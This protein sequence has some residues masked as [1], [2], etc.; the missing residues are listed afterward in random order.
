M[1]WNINALGSGVGAYI[2]ADKTD[3]SKAIFTTKAELDTYTT[4]HPNWFKSFKSDECVAIGTSDVELKYAYIKKKDQWVDIA[5]NFKGDKGEKGNTGNAGADGADGKDGESVEVLINGESK[6]TKLKELDVISAGL[7]TIVQDDKL[8]IGNSAIVSSQGEIIKQ[9]DVSSG[10]K[11]EVEDNKLTIG[12]SDYQQVK[13]EAKKQDDPQIVEINKDQN[14]SNKEFIINYAAE[15]DNPVIVKLYPR[16]DTENK[17]IIITTKFTDSSDPIITI[18][19]IFD[20]DSNLIDTFNLTNSNIFN[21]FENVF[22]CRCNTQYFI[23]ED[24]FIAEKYNG[25]INNSSQISMYISNGILFLS[26]RNKYPENTIDI[27]FWWTSNQTPTKEDILNAFGQE[28]SDSLV[29][30][31]DNLFEDSLKTFTFTAKRE[32]NSFKYLYFAW[33]K[34]FFDPE[35]TLV[36]TDLGGNSTWLRNEVDVDGQIYIT[37]TVEVTN[38]LQ[39]RKGYKLVQEGVR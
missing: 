6:I 22:N 29:S 7:A 12:L 19:K 34:G 4:A 17:N 39:E 23:D 35:P 8:T 32:E 16:S 10:L 25:I 27:V 36:E 15:I 24:K 26:D 13:I 3:G 20:N 21:Q 1:S 33:K 28:Q 5:T 38:N 11:S 37:L 30:H 14:D 2:I 9:I 18:V 31:H